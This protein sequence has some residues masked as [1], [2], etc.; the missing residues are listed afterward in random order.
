MTVTLRRGLPEAERAAAAALYWQAFG[1]KLGLVLGPR[2]RALGFLRQVIRADHVIVA[3]DGRGRLVGMAGFRTAEGSFAGGTPAELRGHYGRLGAAWRL[4]LMWALAQ[5]DE[6]GRFHLDGI[7]VAEAAR[8]QG[9]GTALLAA[10]CDEA[11]GR[12]HAAVRLEVVDTNPRARALYERLG[13]TVE[14]ETPIGLLRHV[15]RFRAALS[16]VRPV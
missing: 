3:L 13:F 12:G 11:R 16:M 9:I 8:G 10:I 6:D 14:R 1:P 7:C 5:D 2:R 4:P 15:F